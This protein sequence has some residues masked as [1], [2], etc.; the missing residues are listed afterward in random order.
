M[1]YIISFTLYNKFMRQ[2][3]QS[4]STREE[5]RVKNGGIQGHKD[6]KIHI[7]LCCAEFLSCV[8]LLATPWTGPHQ[9]PL[10]MEFSRLEYWSG[11][12]FPP[13]EYLCSRGIE[14][15]SPILQADS[16]PSEPTREAH[17]KL[18]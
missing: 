17:I 14:P 16:L 9:A 8:Q 1:K 4:H 10:F 2:I 3:L 11:L 15:R 12:P 18:L 7:K 13:P 5:N 6:G